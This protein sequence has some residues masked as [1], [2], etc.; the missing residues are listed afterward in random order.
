MKSK[1]LKP[2]LFIAMKL[3]AYISVALAA[4]HKLN[5]K[6]LKRPLPPTMYLFIKKCL[7]YA[8]FFKLTYT[9][10]RDGV[11]EFVDDAL[12]KEGLNDIKENLM[13]MT[14]TELYSLYASSEVVIRPKGDED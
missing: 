3:F 14:T 1:L 10:A 11:D 6:T 4:L 8:V 5:T 12:T 13:D 9:A 7:I 2:F